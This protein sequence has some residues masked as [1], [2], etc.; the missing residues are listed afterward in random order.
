MLET[1]NE[2]EPRHGPFIFP[3]NS[4]A[5][6]PPQPDQ[7]ADLLFKCGNLKLTFIKTQTQS[8]TCQKLSIFNYRHL[9]LYPIRLQGRPVGTSQRA[10][11]ERAC[12][13][14]ICSH[15]ATVMRS[16]SVIYREPYYQPKQ[17]N[18]LCKCQ[19]I[20]TYKMRKDIAHVPKNR[21]TYVEK[22]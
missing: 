10:F 4:S 6:T 5:F 21:K 17:Q 16:G 14:Y 18:L 2:P 13:S 9:N 19:G 7:S 12:M 1:I 3:I 20:K 15:A 8:E 11:G 22:S